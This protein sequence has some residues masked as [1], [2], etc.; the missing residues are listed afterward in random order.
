MDLERWHCEG[1]VEVGVHLY[2]A[3]LNHVSLKRTLLLSARQGK[4]RR[5]LLFGT[6]LKL[7]GQQI[8]RLYRARFQ[9]EFLV[10][11]AKS[12]AG[13]THCQ[14]RNAQTLHNHWNA[15]FAVVN[16]AKLTAKPPTEATAPIFSFSSCRQ[17]QRNVHFLQVVSGTLGLD[18]NAIKAHSLQNY[19]VIA[20]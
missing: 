8:V 2:S 3:T 1:E 17:K 5:I 11:D 10:R 20:P 13:L 15:A 18:W 4:Q 7:T 12:G 19:A 16:L 9:I 14:S 6:D